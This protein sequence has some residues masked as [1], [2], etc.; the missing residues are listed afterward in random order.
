MAMLKRIAVAVVLFAAA[1]APANAAETI[2]RFVSDIAVQRNGDLLVTETIAV[3][4]EGERIKRGI[5]REFLTS[6]RN[7]DGTHV[8]IGLE[9]LSVK[10]DGA[11][12]TFT[13]ERHDNGTRIR[14]G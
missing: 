7:S 4:A 10:R 14:I 1:L 8:E 5:L 13:T 6:Y 3:T 11:P 9:V 2:T 12:E